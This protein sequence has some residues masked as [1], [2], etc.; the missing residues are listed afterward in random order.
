MS[1]NES[2]LA[3]VSIGLIQL[4]AVIS[5]GPSFLIVARTAVARSRAE[6]VKVAIGLAAGT[7]VWSSAALIG[8]NSL[9]K[10]MPL[11]FALMKAVGALFLLWIACQTIKH[12]KAPLE[13]N[14]A[15]GGV[16]RN[17]YLQG[18]LT[19]ISNPK[20]AVFF[21]SIFIAILPSEIP[22]WMIIGLIAIVSFNE[23]WWYSLVSV[24][25]GSGPI[26][27]YYIRIKC[28]VDRVT[29]AFLG[30]LGIKLLVDAA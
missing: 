21:G 2:A 11:V 19:Q 26:R 25:C 18:F 5:P 20:V 3:L 16:S 17:P 15:A 29:G 23:F 13:I 6:G 12:A 9:F 7:V 24:F 1:I 8:L 30:V 10:A 22:P 27:A 4:L 14:V 28:S